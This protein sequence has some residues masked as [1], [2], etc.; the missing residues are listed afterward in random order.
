MR[1]SMGKSQF[2]QIE[3][4]L[5]ESWDAFTELLRDTARTPLDPNDKLTDWWVSPMLVK[6]EA[7]G[8]SR[9]EDDIDAMAAWI[10]QDIDHHHK[11]LTDLRLTI[12]HDAPMICYT[13]AS[14]TPSEM[15]WRVMLH[16]D[17]QM[18]PAE[19]R[20]VWRY[21]SRRF[22]GDRQTC[23]VNR[24]YYVPRQFTGDSVFYAQRGTPLRVDAILAIEPEQQ[25]V[26]TPTSTGYSTGL[27]NPPGG[28]EIITG[29]MITAAGPVEG[30]RLYRI[31]CQAALRYR[32]NG[33]QLSSID[34]EMAAMQVS[35]IISP[36][37]KRPGLGREADRA[38]RWAET[39]ATPE[40]P[41]E[42]IR[43]RILWERSK[44][45]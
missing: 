22:G 16:M 2:G 12:G 17:R 15:R 39:H 38:L 20:R 41:L 21:Y 27:R 29:P 36:G 6:T 43:N 45:L 34:L 37:K 10:G 7:L 24:F 11:T 8:K 33:W 44:R 13:T 26:H 42:R 1:W 40:S 23:N 25:Y 4:V 18:T 3:E 31:M 35:S 14:S 5:D 9:L 19:Y 32:K 30:G 28:S